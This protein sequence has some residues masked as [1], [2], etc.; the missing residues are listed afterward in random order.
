MNFGCGRRGAH[1]LMRV[2]GGRAARGAALALCLL[3]APALGQGRDE[4]WRPPAGWVLKPD[5]AY[6]A[7]GNFWWA[8]EKDRGR[9]TWDLTL[10]PLI[11]RG[12]CRLSRG[13]EHFRAVGNV[14]AIDTEGA[15]HVGLIVVDEEGY[16]WVISPEAFR[17][18]G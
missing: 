14:M 18:P 3:A 10:S 6:C 12:A 15:R 16:E 1:G 9:K 11:S 7:D 2:G 13:G 8:Q 4:D 5:F 17:A